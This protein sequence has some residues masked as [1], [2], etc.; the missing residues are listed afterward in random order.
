M[1]YFDKAKQLLN[2]FKGDSY[3]FGYNIL[4]RVGGICATIGEKAVIINTEFPGIHNLISELK[5]SLKTAGVE[6]ISEVKGPRPNAPREDV[7]RIAGELLTASPDV[8]ISFGGGSTIDA[9]KAASVLWTLNGDIDDYFGTGLVTEKLKKSGKKLIDHVAIQTAASSAAHLTKYSNI[10][11]LET[12]QKKLIVDEAIIPQ[13]PIFDYRATKTAPVALTTD[14]ALDGMAHII[15]VLYWAEGKPIFNNM[16]EI[17]ETGVSLILKYLPKVIKD[18]ENSIGR[19][20][21]CLATDLG[22]YA[23]SIGGTNGGHLTSFSL[24]D[25]LSHGRACAIMNPYYT[26][27][28]TD[29]IEESLRLLGRLYRENGFIN[30]NI[31][32]LKV[33]ELGKTVTRGMFEFARS[34]GFPIALSE[35]DGFTDNHIERALSAAKNPQLKMKLENMPVPLSAEMIDEF[36]RPILVAA[37]TGDISIIKSVGRKGA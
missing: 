13:H 37:K 32:S 20:A 25:I 4:S 1:N 10:T 34:I 8:I 5:D 28:F 2:E 36:M 3:N 26:V 17:A 21:L 16:V 6:V 35:V 27:F 23:I 33:R 9:V 7:C 18:P 15:E 24:I 14:G 29:A 11:N 31:E 12:C 22:G 30:T 19:E